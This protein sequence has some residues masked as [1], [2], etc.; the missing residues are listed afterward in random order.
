MHG[1]LAECHH[2]NLP[3][4]Q[5][6]TGAANEAKTEARRSEKKKRKRGPGGG[7]LTLIERRERTKNGRED[8]RLDPE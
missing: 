5:R 1:A 6:T 7:Y 8:G 4:G 2:R 3:R